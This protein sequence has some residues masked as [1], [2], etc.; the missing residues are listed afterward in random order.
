MLALHFTG[1]RKKADTSGLTMGFPSPVDKW[2]Y[3]NSA[4]N[5]AFKR[6]AIRLH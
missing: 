6:M 3:C 2:L 4:S 1:V 5:R